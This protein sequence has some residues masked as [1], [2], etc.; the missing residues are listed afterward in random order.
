MEDSKKKI[1]PLFFCII[2]YVSII[3]CRGTAQ[4]N[5]NTLL[6]PD[7]HKDPILT[8]FFEKD[9]TEG[10]PY[11]SRKWIP[12]VVELSNHKRI[13]E[14]DKPM[15]FNFDKINNVIY[16]V[17][18]TNKISVY[19]AD[20][21]LSFNL[22]DNNMVFSFEKIAWIS[23]NFFL[24]PVIKSAK[25]YSLYKRLFTKFMRADYSSEGYYT[26]GKRYD[27]YI[28]YYEYYVT[29][30]GNSLFRKL[31]LKEKDIR[32]ALKGES[33][34]L[35]EFFSIHDNEINDQSLVGIIQY[36]NDKKYPD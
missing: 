35:D 11:L 27:E 31:Y 19:P 15:L 23:D 14:P 30:P 29:Y 13:P 8:T 16:T 4:Q 2:I 34:L 20:S 33:K 18:R 3:L 26:K 28:D 7:T 10:S 21:V 6:P 9:E 1:N 25:G 12:G 17:N 32:R 5:I 22:V 36:I 24:M